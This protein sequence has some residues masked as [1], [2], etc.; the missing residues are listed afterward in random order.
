MAI[1]SLTH[2][3]T[4]V[5]GGGYQLQPMAIQSSVSCIFEGSRRWEKVGESGRGRA[6]DQ[7]SVSRTTMIGFWLRLA[8]RTSLMHAFESK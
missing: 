2:L 8:A 4:R 1:L 6:R 7:C 5:L 3:H